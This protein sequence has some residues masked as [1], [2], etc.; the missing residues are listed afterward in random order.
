MLLNELVIYSPRQTQSCRFWTPLS[1]P[2]QNHFCHSLVSLPVSLYG[3]AY[4]D[5][6]T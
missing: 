4:A 2:S 6:I 5:V 3:R 1:P